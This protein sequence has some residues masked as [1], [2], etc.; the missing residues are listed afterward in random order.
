MQNIDIEYIKKLISNDKLEECLNV[1]IS[2]NSQNIEL[3]QLK[4]R[5]ENL[6]QH[7][8]IGDLSNDDI[9]RNRN[10]IRIS[11]LNVLNNDNDASKGKTQT[12]SIEND[13]NGCGVILGVLIFIVCICLLF[14]LI[15]KFEI[16]D[17][18]PYRQSSY[19]ETV[20]TKDTI[21]PKLITSIIEKK[22]TAYDNS[23]RK[24]EYII[25]L[26]KGFNW[27]I[28]EIDKSEKYGTQQDICEHIQD[29]GIS[30]RINRNDLKGIICLGNTSFEEDITVPKRLRKKHEEDR[31]D[32]RAFILA[33]CISSALKM[34]TPVYTSNLGK[35]IESSD[36]SAYQREIIVVGVLNKDDN[37][38]N[39]EALFNGF[40]DLY[41]LENWEIDIRK[42]SKI[43][44]NKIIID[45]FVN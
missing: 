19:T 6:N 40:V 5:L 12:K 36:I 4:G 9:F 17:F 35:Y 22:I 23:G 30:E 8:I 3:L 13:H 18:K 41:E 16:P 39:E 42:Y 21:K 24:V 38:V 15:S 45:N 7:K 1:L 43:L 26:I 28:N 25:F 37:A 29:V 14:F 31:A 20:K 10:Q 32:I 44:D 27:Q 33:T 2:L 11:L 34:K